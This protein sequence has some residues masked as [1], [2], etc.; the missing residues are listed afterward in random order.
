MRLIVYFLLSFSIGNFDIKQ[1]HV[2]RVKFNLLF[3]LTN[4]KK[5]SWKKQIKEAN[6][7]ALTLI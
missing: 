4:K 1:R 2:I 5:A 7:K 6:I 3:Y